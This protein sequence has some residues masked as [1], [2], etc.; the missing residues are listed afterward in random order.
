MSTIIN[1]NDIC[2]KCGEISTEPCNVCNICASCC[3]GIKCAL[4]DKYSHNAISHLDDTDTCMKICDSCLAS[5]IPLPKDIVL[6]TVKL[7][8]ENDYYNYNDLCSIS[9]SSFGSDYSGFNTSATVR[10]NCI[11]D[12]CTH[13]REYSPSLHD[14]EYIG[15][16]LL[17]KN[18]HFIFPDDKCSLC[19]YKD[20]PCT[21]YNPIC[22][23]TYH[24]YCI[25]KYLIHQIS[26]CPSCSDPHYCKACINC[27]Y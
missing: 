6:F 13:F 27:D 14:F 7:Y 17:T 2:D 23:C 19:I 25:D 16:M 21:Y 10:K 4:C 1:I 26:E 8:I 12:H 22:G 24:K 20:N 9:V 5:V 15:N 3:G 11:C 18:K